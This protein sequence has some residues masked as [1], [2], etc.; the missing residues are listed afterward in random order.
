MKF[1][2][3]ITLESDDADVL[4]EALKKIDPPGV[5]GFT[6]VVRVV[7]DPAATILEAWLDE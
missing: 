7:P 2:I 5:P 4:V 1:V 3:T 6:G